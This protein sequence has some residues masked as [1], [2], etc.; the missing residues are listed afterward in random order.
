MIANVLLLAA[1]VAARGSELILEKIRAV[2]DPRVFDL[3]D[4]LHGDR[5]VPMT[6]ASSDGTQITL[7]RDD[8]DATLEV[9]RGGTT[10]RVDVEDVSGLWR[11]TLA[12]GQ[13]DRFSYVN[14]RHG[15]VYSYSADRLFR[16]QDPVIWTRQVAPFTSI[17]EVAGNMTDASV[18]TAGVARSGLLLVE[19]F[20]RKDGAT[21]FWHEVIDAA[22]GSSLGKFGPSDL[23]LKTNDRDPGWVLFQGGG[24]DTN[25]YVPQA[26]YRLRIGRSIAGAQ[27]AAAVVSALRSSPPP[28]RPS[29]SAKLSS[30]P[31]INHMIALLTPTR[32]AVDFH[33]EFCPVVPADRARYWLGADYSP[34]AGSVARDILLAFLIERQRG[35]HP[36]STLDGWFQSEI[37]AY[38]PMRA[39]LARFDPHDDRWVAQYQEALLA[40]G[41]PT[42]DRLFTQYGLGTG[43]V[44]REPSRSDAP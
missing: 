19:W 7:T 32:T 38:D 23:L 36:E 10:R 35:N 43:A 41:R 15:Q 39:V 21:E 40:I 20:Y 1:A 17:D 44:R 33:I 12:C 37:A 31:V 11:S 16:G 30:N 5:G 29:P 4:D 26:L 22:T 18:A 8:R 9:R 2:D 13:G 34:E 27:P 28:M 24:T 42:F 6:C 14:P 25:N 3:Q